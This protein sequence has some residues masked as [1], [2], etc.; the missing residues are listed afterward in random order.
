MQ[1][2]LKFID[3]LF[4]VAFAIIVFLSF[5]YL[6]GG[7][8]INA[9]TLVVKTPVQKYA[10][11]LSK[12]ADLSFEGTIGITKVRIEHGEAYVYESACKNKLCISCGKLRR[13]NDY[14]ACLPNGI[15]LYVEG[16]KKKDELDAVVQ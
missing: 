15:I 13:V 14:A 4:I 12:D 3:I 6:L 9:D 8:S 10:Y 5:F 11:S 1:Y 16:E 2:K 7:K